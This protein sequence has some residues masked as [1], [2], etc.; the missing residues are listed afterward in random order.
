MNDQVVTLPYRPEL[1]SSI[2]ELWNT[3]L[4]R[5]PVSEHIFAA[6]VL[7]DPNF[8]PQG[9]L[10]ACLEDAQANLTPV[11]FGLALCRRRPLPGVGLQEDLG[12]ITAF[13]VH[14]DY[15]GRGI[16]R[17]LFAE[18]ESYLKVKGRRTIS[19][20]DYA[21]NYFLP[22][23][24][25]ETYASG[26]AFLKACGY[27]AVHEVLGM[28]RDLLDLQTPAYVAGLRQKLKDE[29]VSVETLTPAMCYALLSFLE[30]EFPGDWAETARAKLAKPE[31]YRDFVIARRDLEVVGY[32]Q[33]DGE[34]F[35]PF[36]VAASE[37]GSGL[38]T[39]LFYS[40]VER[41]RA[42]GLRH[43]W[44]AWTGGAAA[45]FYTAKGGLKVQRRQQIMRKKLG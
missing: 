10:T 16:G 9:L 31:G 29:G 3:C 25:T 40:L 39:V 32:C 6:K 14:P 13:G 34:R 5:D 24:D 41:M 8:E 1:F 2:I 27:T 17:R 43:M 7:Q 45:R 33:H 15:R 30:K 35:G 38:G 26:F 22:G 12:W 42:E 19:V 28:G 18:L 44:L 21:P 37:R 11:G 36:G 23:V 20:A 4:H